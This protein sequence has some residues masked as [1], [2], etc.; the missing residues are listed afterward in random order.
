MTQNESIPPLP[1]SWDEVPGM[2]VTVGSLI[3]LAHEIEQVQHN[4][5]FLLRPGGEASPTEYEKIIRAATEFQRDSKLAILRGQGR[6]HALISKSA[7]LKIQELQR[8]KEAI[9]NDNLER[10]E[11]AFEAAGFH[12]KHVTYFRISCLYTHGGP[13]PESTWRFDPVAILLYHCDPRLRFQAALRVAELKTESSAELLIEA[14][15][16]NDD[17]VRVAASTS[18]GMIGPSAL[19]PCIEGLRHPDRNVRGGCASA[20]GEIGD[21]RTVDPILALL[22]DP[23]GYVRASAVGTLVKLK[24][25]RSLDALVSS[26][27]DSYSPA[28]CLAAEALGEIRDRKALQSLTNGLKHSDSD[29]RASCARA[30]GRLGQKEAVPYLV[31]CLDDDIPYVR[32]CT[33]EALG[34]LGESGALADLSKLV[35]FWRFEKREVKQAAQEAIA[36]IKAKRR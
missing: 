4:V 17:L 21:K 2:T 36:K 16:D 13:V 19:Q 7:F 25:A 5:V 24:D 26:L 30:L 15:T 31:K 33:C 12:T 18:L 8:G 28:R 34:E 9:D 32:K 1:R 22:K 10:L 6:T 3:S 14:L 27:S 20:L 29:M 35:S 11:R 23:E